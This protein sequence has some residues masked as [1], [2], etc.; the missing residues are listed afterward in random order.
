[1]P[2]EGGPYVQVACFCETVLQEQTNVWS[3]IRIVDTITHGERGQDPPEEMP[4]FQYSLTMVVMLKSGTARGR[5]E[6]SIIPERPN[7][8]ALNP[9]SHSVHFEGEEKGHNFI[10]NMNMQYDQEGLYLFYVK[11][12]EET[13]TV[14][15]LRVK[16]QRVVIG[17]PPT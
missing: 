14:L 7:G 11:M 8:S 17:P 5:H 1:M 15:P 6:I 16:Y 3:L 12:G 10:I 2:L 13:L 9:I 4:S